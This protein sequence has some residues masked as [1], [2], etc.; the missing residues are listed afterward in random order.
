MVVRI[1]IV[2]LGDENLA[3][4]LPKTEGKDEMDDPAY[5]PSEHHV[6][7]LCHVNAII[8][9]DAVVRDGVREVLG[10]PLF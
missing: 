7:I 8:H 6:G 9:G 3:F 1:G 4:G 2:I 5:A 10:E